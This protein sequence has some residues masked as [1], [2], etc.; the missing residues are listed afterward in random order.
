MKGI[1]GFSQA[2]IGSNNGNRNYLGNIVPFDLSEHAGERI[3]LRLVGP[4]VGVGVHWIE[5]KKKGGGIGR[6]PKLCLN[7][8][9]DI[10]EFEDA[11]CPYCEVARGSRKYLVNA[12]IRSEQD[13][14]PKKS[15]ERTKSEKKLKDLGGYEC[16]IKEPGSKS[17]TPVQPLMLPGGVAYELK[18]LTANNL[19]KKGNV[20]ELSDPKYGMDISIRYNPEKAGES[21]Y[22]VDTIERTPLTEEEKEYL[23]HDITD[24]P[25]ESLKTAREEFERFEA[26]IIVSSRDKDDVDDDEE[27]DVDD[28]RPSKKSKRKYEDDDEDEAPRKKKKS[29]DDDDDEDDDLEDID[30]DDE[31]DEKPRKKS[32][33]KYEDDDDEDEDESPKRKKSKKSYDDFDDDEDDDFDDDEDDEEPRKKKKSFDSSSKHKK[34]KSYYDDDDEDFDDEDESPK[35]KKKKK[36]YDDDDDDEDEKPR[37]KKKS[38]DDD[39]ELDDLD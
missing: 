8:N 1:K 25:V 5:I 33:R 35:S 38:F 3:R 16:H 24:I 19:D 21:K 7:Y 11:G 32:K 37:K 15:P 20:R 39:D 14:E 26:S 12:I 6:F 22:R 17:W 34:K 30:D 29:Y 28:E 18:D 13:N 23:L 31:E 9:S 4:V 27:L 10:D 36:S 2:K